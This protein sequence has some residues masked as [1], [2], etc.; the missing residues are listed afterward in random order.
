M[1][2]LFVSYSAPINIIQTDSCNNISVC[3]PGEV[4]RSNPG[5]TTICFRVGG[6]GCC[7]SEGTEDPQPVYSNEVCVTIPPD[8]VGTLG[9]FDFNESV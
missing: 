2:N 6:Q 4:L 7:L 8:Y 9:N 3:I 1:N 5:T